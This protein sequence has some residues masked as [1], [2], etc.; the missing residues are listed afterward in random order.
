[1]ERAFLPL[2]PSAVSRQLSAAKAFSRQLSAK[3]VLL[4]AES[5]T[6]DAN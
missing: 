2:K 4:T 6:L 5:W 1:L 3:P